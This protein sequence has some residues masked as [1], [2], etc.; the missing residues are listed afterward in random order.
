MIRVTS[1]AKFPLH[2][3][4]RDLHGG[5]NT[6]PASA[7][8]D[9]HRRALSWLRL[10]LTR[11]FLVGFSTCIADGSHFG[12]PDARDGHHAPGARET[13]GAQERFFGIFGSPRHQEWGKILDLRVDSYLQETA[14]TK[15]GT[16]LHA[17]GIRYQP[18]L[19]IHQVLSNSL[20]ALVQHRNQPASKSPTEIV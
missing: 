16:I 18:Y 11:L 20:A 8:K 4:K 2:L 3:G 15:L 1:S 13:H 9:A 17:R 6:S 12:K 5:A 7:K 10:G 19:S 14:C